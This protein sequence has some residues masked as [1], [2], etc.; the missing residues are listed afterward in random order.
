[1]E[2]E[3]RDD[4]KKENTEEKVEY[5]SVTVEANAGQYHETCRQTVMYHYPNS[6]ISDELPE[7]GVVIANK[8]IE[9]FGLP[10]WAY[11]FYVQA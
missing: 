11:V 5:I 10:T 1:M 4:E 9:T 7:N 8:N 6:Y 2:N 3:M